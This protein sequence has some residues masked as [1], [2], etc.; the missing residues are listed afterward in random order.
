MKLILTALNAKYIHT[1]L[2]VRCLARAVE[3]VCDCSIREYTINDPV[4]EICSELHRQ[5]A[6]CIAF[7]CYI[8]NIEN[9]LKICSFLKKANPK[10]TIV[11]GGYEAMY[12]S[13]ELMEE[14]P[15]IDAVIRGEGEITLREYIET[16]D[17]KKSL[18][19]VSGITYRSDDEIIQNPD[20]TE[21]CDINALPFPYDDTIDE[22][23]NKIIY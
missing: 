21:L 11:L 12:D 2:S 15:Y 13:R 22:I 9:I 7:S 6:D 5:K 1:S 10:L 17:S 3:D 18:D 19:C 20:R 4:G 8:W 23:K 16:L 14:H